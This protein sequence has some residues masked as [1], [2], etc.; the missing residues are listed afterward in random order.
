MDSDFAQIGLFK[1]KEVGKT[2][3]NGCN[4]YYNNAAVPEYCSNKQ[5]NAFI[6][7][8]ADKKLKTPTALIFNKNMASVRVHATGHPTRTFVALGDA[9]KVSILTVERVLPGSKPGHGCTGGGG[10]CVR[11]KI[12]RSKPK[13]A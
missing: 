7:G 2:K 9:K 8:R 1:R 6:G 10:V 3:C 12:L 13:L 5:C 4:A 11:V